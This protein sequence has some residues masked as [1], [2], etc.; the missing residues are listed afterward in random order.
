MIN[1]KKRFVSAFIILSMIVSVIPTSLTAEANDTVNKDQMEMNKKILTLKDAE[2]LAYVDFSYENGI[3]EKWENQYYDLAN[4]GNNKLTLDEMQKITDSYSIVFRARL[5]DRSNGTSNYTGPRD[6]TILTIL[7]N[8]DSHLDTSAKWSEG[9][10]IGI[11]G[12]NDSVSGTAHAMYYEIRKDYEYINE[13]TDEKVYTCTELSQGGNDYS[14]T[15][16]ADVSGDGDYH[17]IALVYTGNG[18]NYY[19]DGKLLDFVDT[20][21]LNPQYGFTN[22]GDVFK[23]YTDSTKFEAWIGRFHMRNSGALVNANFD[24]FAF[25]GEALTEEQVINLSNPEAPVVEYYEDISKFRSV[26]QSYTYDTKKGYTFAGWYEDEECTVPLTE[27]K[28]NIVKGAFA[29]YV[30]DKILSIKGQISTRDYDFTTSTG[31]I[32]QG[33]SMKFI[34]SVD[35]LK[36]R[37]VG[38]KFIKHT[39]EGDKQAVVSSGNVCTKIFAIGTNTPV[40]YTPQSSFCKES[41]Y[42]KTYT[43]TNMPTS[44]YGVEITAIPYWVTVDGTTVYGM[45]ATKSIDEGTMAGQINSSDSIVATVTQ[46]SSKIEQPWEQFTEM[47]AD[48]LKLNTK[49]YMYAPQGGYTDGIYFYQAF[50]EMP[51]EATSNEKLEKTNRV[52]ICT[53]DMNG[54]IVEGKCKLIEPDD[55]EGTGSLNHANDITYNS[56]RGCFIVSHAKP[57]RNQI[58]CIDPTTMA[59]I[60]TIEIDYEI[61]SIDYHEDKDLYVV[62]LKG[63]QAFRILDANFHAITPAF[64][65]TDKTVGYTT[66]GVTCD[67]NFIYFVL[68]KSN[69]V[70]VYDWKGQFVTLIDLESTITS[71]STYSE[72][73]GYIIDL[74]TYSL[75]N[76]EPEN[77][78]V[79]GNK[80]YIG[81]CY[82]DDAAKHGTYSSYYVDDGID[83]FVFFELSNF[84]SK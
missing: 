66:Q 37:E 3:S 5:N 79:I 58:T 40:K 36:Y 83:S 13:E 35:S 21:E 24:W 63:T 81:C 33:R 52:L 72:T 44:D 45:Q 1:I 62:G 11:L 32:K 59:V 22:I 84:I 18:F 2:A 39:S 68:Y 8:G 34:T 61:I 60:E 50:I 69:T 56:K 71:K 17:T 7:P 64:E 41:T 46:E 25:Y 20:A 14:V 30:S 26:E 53:Y 43:L 28:A 74:T 77:I 57:N 49:E 29:K 67:D 6:R 9:L 82:N 16:A 70:V 51:V 54:N 65:P 76:Y 47:D 23:E 42:F 48:T 55:E 75:G 4:K 31:E 12:G 73:L 15:R 78:T 19:V 80:L 10:A 38:F 27:T